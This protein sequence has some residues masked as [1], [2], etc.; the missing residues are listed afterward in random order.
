MFL[1]SLMLCHFP[2]SDLGLAPMILCVQMCLGSNWGTT[3]LPSVQLSTVLFFPQ[4]YFMW[5]AGKMSC[6]GPAALVAS[7]SC[8]LQPT[9]SGLSGPSHHRCYHCL[10]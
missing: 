5:Q 8:L 3:W 10:V 9:P 2:F 1:G 6:E 4:E 7:Q